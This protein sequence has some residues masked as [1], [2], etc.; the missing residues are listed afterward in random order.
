MLF[1]LLWY[2]ISIKKDAKLQKCLIRRQF[3]AILRIQNNPAENIL[4]V[5]IKI[6]WNIK[7]LRFL[8][9][10][11]FIGTFAL[12]DE[13]TIVSAMLSDETKSDNETGIERYKEDI[14]TDKDALLD[15]SSSLDATDHVQLKKRSPAGKLNIY[16]L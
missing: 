16:I 7:M 6:T 2:S 3:H 8:F 5:N 13:R 1:L 15:E 10:V 12:T 11:L 4:E 14:N 9:F